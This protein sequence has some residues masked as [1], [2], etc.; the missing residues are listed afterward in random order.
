MREMVRRVASARRWLTFP[1]APSRRFSLGDTLSQARLSQLFDLRILA[2]ILFSILLHVVIMMLF[3]ALPMPE[4]GGRIVRQLQAFVADAPELDP[5]P[6]EQEVELAEPSDEASESALSQSVAAVASIEDV[7]ESLVNEIP[8]TEMAVDL[9]LPEPQPL[10]SLELDKVLVTQGTVG[11]EVSTVEGAV[12]RITYEIA[13]NLEQSDVLVLWLMDASISL[14]EHRQTVADRLQRVYDEITQLGTVSPDALQSSVVAFG[15]DAQPLVPPTSDGAA[16]IEAIRNVPLDESGVENVFSAVVASVNQYKALRTRER[17]KLIVVVWTDE[18]GDDLNQLDE[19]ASICR[20]LAV[21]VF[22]V[23]PSSMFG[24]RE[25]TTSYRHPE[26]GQTYQLPVD[27]GPDTA[28]PE[29][30]QLPF[31]FDG[32]KYENLRAGVGPYGLVRLALESGGAY[33]INDQEAD[34]SPFRLASMKRYL[35][36]YIPPAQYLQQVDKNR[37]RQAVLTAV[38]TTQRRVLHGTPR[39]SFAPTAN[40]FQQQ[41]L[42]G[43]KSVADDLLTIE[44]ALS[45]FGPKGMEKE[46]AQ[47][48]SPRWRAWYDLTYGRL[49]AMWVRCNEYN[50]ACAVMKGKGAAFV[51]KES[52]RWEFRPDEQLN[53][54]TASERHATE[55]RRLLERCIAENPD[56]PWAVLAQRELKHPFGFRVDDGY[57]APPEPPKMDLRPGVN[58]PAPPP[59]LRVEE[60]RMLERPDVKLPKL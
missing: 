58:I 20:R 22:T 25:G 38:D 9:Q 53:F 10:A 19:A 47:E 27:R 24:Q 55:A 37:L 31:W 48:T 52:N 46:Y 51:D 3:G 34:R 4:G 56:T 5:L 1:A 6:P 7:A 17:R 40:D 15:L 8:T 18:A 28:R 39:L 41:L 26:D 11:S 49:L 23:G 36:E 21:P 35:P 32:P 12:D 54:G 60:R 44:Q 30:L 45:A 16:V 2:A 59:G 57:V 33:L 42:D 14:R 13:L 50:W 43:Q 29:R